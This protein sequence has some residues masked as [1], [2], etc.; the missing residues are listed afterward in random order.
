MKNFKNRMIT[1]GRTLFILAIL[2]V[3]GTAVYGIGNYLVQEYKFDRL[4]IEE[5]WTKQ[6]CYH[7]GNLPNGLYVINCDRAFGSPDYVEPEV[8]QN[9][10]K[11]RRIK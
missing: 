1:A 8:W 11:N 7:S 2:T 4:S 10:L 3:G 5:Q 6:N 9:Y